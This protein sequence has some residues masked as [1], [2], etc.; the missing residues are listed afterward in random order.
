MLVKSNSLHSASMFAVFGVFLGSVL[1]FPSWAMD[2]EEGS[3]PI[4]PRISSISSSQAQ[5]ETVEERP[6]L[7][8]GKN[9]RSREESIRIYNI[10]SDA[11]YN[12][13]DFDF[14]K[15]SKWY[16]RKFLGYT[17]K[18]LGFDESGKPT[19]FNRYYDGNFTWYLNFL[20]D[21]RVHIKNSMIN[22]SF[23]VDEDDL[24][25]MVEKIL[26]DIPSTLEQ[27]LIS[28]LVKNTGIRRPLEMKDGHIYFDNGELAYCSPNTTFAV[29][30]KGKIFIRGCGDG[31]TS[32]PDLLK[33]KYA[34]CAGHMG[35]K[36]G[37]IN[38][39]WNSSGHY[40]TT[41]YHFYT[42]VEFL[43]NGNFFAPT[44]V[45]KQVSLERTTVELFL[46]S[47]NKEDLRSLWEEEAKKRLSHTPF[48]KIVV[49]KSLSKK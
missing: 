7:K 17:G 40:L 21:K 33:G 9:L 16:C 3:F 42:F 34:W 23:A 29:N 10:I 19:L 39:L 30:T 36:D 15:F 20:K 4:Q 8:I 13:Q 38:Y 6:L 31:Y 32:H 37:K 28:E 14:T 41:L 24:H 45:I 12:G 11:G 25:I 5:L 44:A 46:A 26:K 47:F 49:A 18:E 27:V 43:Q 48:L 2:P 35:A 22:E 1:S